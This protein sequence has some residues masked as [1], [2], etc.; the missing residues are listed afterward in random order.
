MERNGRE[1]IA[2][3]ENNPLQQSISRNAEHDEAL[4]QELLKN[5]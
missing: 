2:A 1:M 4:Y 5:M 3:V